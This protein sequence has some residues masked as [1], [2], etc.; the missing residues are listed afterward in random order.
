M[1]HWINDAR[2]LS[3]LYHWWL[4]RVTLVVAFRFLPLILG[5]DRD[6]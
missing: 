5:G 6:L 3:N 2:E 1:T 4:I